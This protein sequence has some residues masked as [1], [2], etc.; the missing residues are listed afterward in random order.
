MASDATVTNWFGDLVSH[1]K[2][3]VEAA[4]V[5]EIVRILNISVARSA[6]RLEPFD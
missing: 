2:A 4:S 6:Y 5:D 3:V 1:P